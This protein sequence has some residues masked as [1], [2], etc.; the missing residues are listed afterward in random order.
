MTTL[1]VLNV[2]DY[3]QDDFFFKFLTHFSDIALPLAALMQ[4]AVPNSWLKKRIFSSRIAL[5][6]QWLI[7]LMFLSHGYKCVLLST[8]VPIQYSKVKL[9]IIKKGE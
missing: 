3:L 1:R 6:G 5:I 4:E 8:L 2:E 7:C 9:V